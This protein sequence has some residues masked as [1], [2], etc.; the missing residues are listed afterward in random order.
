MSYTALGAYFGSEEG[1]RLLEDAR[2]QEAKGQ[3][4]EYQIARDAVNAVGKDR[5]LLKRD[6]KQSLLSQ[7]TSEPRLRRRAGI[8]RSGAVAQRGGTMPADFAGALDNQMRRT[9]MR[10]RMQNMG[11]EQVGQ[12]SLRDRISVAQ[13]SRG[14]EYDLI[15][16]FGKSAQIR[17][18]INI[19]TGDAKQALKEGQYGAAGTVL[20][21]GLSAWINGAF[22]N[23]FKRGG[24]GGRRRRRRRAGHRPGRR[25]RSISYAYGMARRGRLDTLARQ[26]L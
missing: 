22:D 23:I 6:R 19:A 17:K 11:E 15:N 26:H 14:R 8:E 13:A 1:R 24:G 7:I 20:G 16:A 18:G 12:Q 10:T 4:A 5:F 3:M 2:R 9:K 25:T 21:A